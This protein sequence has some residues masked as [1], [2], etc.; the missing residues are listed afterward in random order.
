VSSTSSK[1]GAFH[2]H[3]RRHSATAS[4]DRRHERAE[5]LCRQ[6]AVIGRSEMIVASSWIDMLAG[7]SGLYI[8][9]IPPCF[10]AN[11][12]WAANSAATKPPVAR[13]ARGLRFILPLPDTG[14]GGRRIPALFEWGCRQ[15]PQLNPAISAAV[16]SSH[17]TRRCRESLPRNPQGGNMAKGANLTQRSL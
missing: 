11:I 8:L 13:I 12:G 3:G 9:R 6:A 15:N 7:L 16:S 10:W 5:A 2:E 4:H 14:A 17:S 1:T